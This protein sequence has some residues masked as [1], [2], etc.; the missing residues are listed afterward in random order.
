MER[1]YSTIPTLVT[2]TNFPT[3]FLSAVFP[4]VSLNYRKLV[5]E[6]GGGGGGERRAMKGNGPKFK[7]VSLN[8]PY[9]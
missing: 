7:T 6:G 2:Q 1:I 8:F 9:L 4:E 5:D 3:M